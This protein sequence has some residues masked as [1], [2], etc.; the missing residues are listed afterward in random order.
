M[1]GGEGKVYDTV[2]FLGSN[3]PDYG[4]N[5][6]EMIPDDCATRLWK[7]QSFIRW[8]TLLTGHIKIIFL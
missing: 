8:S 2:S 7:S 5:C 6:I 1:G 4:V 3:L